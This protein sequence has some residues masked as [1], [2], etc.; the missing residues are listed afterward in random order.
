MWARE[1]ETAAPAAEII[2]N[3]K[4]FQY[5]LENMARIYSVAPKAQREWNKI[6]HSNVIY[7]SL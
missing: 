7:T 5:Q 6:I 2:E 3:I 1:K 4:F